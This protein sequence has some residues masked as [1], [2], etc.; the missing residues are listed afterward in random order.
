M[1]EYQSRAIRLVAVLSAGVLILGAQLFRLTGIQAADWQLEA[2]GNMYRVLVRHGPRGAIYDRK[3]RALATSEPAFAVRLVKQDLDEVERFMPV[4]AMLITDGDTTRAAEITSWVLGEIRS[5]EENQRQ[6]EPI[7]IPAKLNDSM[8]AAFV[9]RKG[10]FPGVMLVEDSVRN[11]PQGQFAGALL[12]YVQPISAEDLEGELK[13]K[14]YGGNEIVGK[15]GLERFYEQALRG[16]DGKRAVTIDTFGRPIDDAQETPPVPGNDLH[17]TLD[18]DLQRVAEEALYRQMQWIREQNDKEANPIR[19]AVVVQ[20]VNTGAILALAS[21]P[22]FDPNQFVR[23]LTQSQVKEL[24]ENPAAPLLNWAIKAQEPGST[25]KMG[26]GLAG[27]ELGAMDPY[28]KIHCAPTYERDPTRRNWTGYDQGW[29][30]VAG[31]L[32]LSCNPYFYETGYRIGIDPLAE[33]LSQ[34]GFGRPTGIDLV[35][36]QAGILPTKAS[37]GDDWQPGHIFSVSIG[38]GD[39]RASPLQIANYTATIAARGVRY[40]PYLVAE[41]R[42]PSGE[43]LQRTVPQQIGVVKASDASWDRIQQ[44]MLQART[45]VYGTAHTGFLNFPISVAAKTG[46]AETGR[47]WSNALTVAYAPFDKPQIAVSV[48]IEGG[49]KGSW[50]APVAR[51]VMAAYFGL[52]DTDKK[53]VPTYKD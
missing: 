15:D 36:E 26:V 35:G 19:G 33:F 43:V 51:R 6:Y 53:G 39:V 21:V 23:G 9:E 5:R 10:E 2:E 28:E 30:D 45:E 13:D 34:F 48:F 20:E 31:A 46:S 41:V 29:A 14:K 11:Y 22:T 37:Y 42:S 1:S 40:R 8:V 16:T 17:L 25:Y 44:G 12:G 49:S 3:G 38:Q 4:L 52:P 47:P 24:F 18:M 32:A 7:T 50:A 27:L